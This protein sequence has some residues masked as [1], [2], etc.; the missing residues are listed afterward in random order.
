MLEI[1]LSAIVFWIIWRIL[2]AIFTR[3]AKTPERFVVK[4]SDG[5]FWL[6]EDKPDEPPA[7]LPDNVTRLDDRR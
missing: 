3:K 6:L 5:L 1:I 7:D 2:D 4:D